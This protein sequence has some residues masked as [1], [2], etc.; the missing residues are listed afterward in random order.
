MTTM[1][2]HI[3]MWRLRGQTEAERHEAAL[4]VRRCF[5]SLR[6]RIPGLLHLEVGIDHS[7]VTVRQ[8]GLDAKLTGVEVAHVVKELLA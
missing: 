4:K 1:V 3:V 8:R 7:R 6:G 5:E 2:K